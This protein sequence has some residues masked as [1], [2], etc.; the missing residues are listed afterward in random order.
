MKKLF[1][2]LS[3]FMFN[4]Y[5]SHECMHA[6]GES[7]VAQK[8]TQPKPAA[9]L[10]SV[11]TLMLMDWA[12]AKVRSVKTKFEWHDY[13]RA[14]DEH[15]FSP[16]VLYFSHDKEKIQFAQTYSSGRSFS[17]T[18]SAVRTLLESTCV[19]VVGSIRLL[20]ARPRQ[21]PR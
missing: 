16:G 12:S 1:L 2:L 5:G 11:L 14:I 19:Y 10:Q 20:F 15:E 21:V 6:L 7:S 18:F 4:R 8:N 17:D 13:E 3:A 9:G